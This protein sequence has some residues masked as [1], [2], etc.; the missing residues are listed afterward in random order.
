M[1]QAKPWVLEETWDGDSVRVTTSQVRTL[2]LDV[3]EAGEAVRFLRCHHCNLPHG[4]DEIHCPITGK[5][6]PSNDGL[7]SVDREVWGMADLIDATVG[8][9]YRIFDVL[10][11]GG[12]GT[13]YEAVDLATGRLAAVKVMRRSL[14]R[15]DR[16]R[17]RFLREAEATQLLDHP[18][19]VRH[20]AAGELPDGSPF[21]ALELLEG[22]PLSRELRELGDRGWLRV[23]EVLTV[24]RQILEGLEAAHARGIVH[25]DIKPDNVFIE[26]TLPGDPISVR[27]LDFGV[28]KVFGEN[29]LTGLTGQEELIGTPQYLAPEQISDPETVCPSTDIWATGIV[30]YQMLTGVTPF[31]GAHL[32]GLLLN[33]ATQPHPEL[34]FFRPELPAYLDALVNRFLQKCPE[35]RFANAAEAIAAVDAVS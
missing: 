32:G 10:G 16:S 35:D 23:D 24:T 8:N 4:V 15:E 6:I 3:D 12:M 5:V 18:R 19:I 13:V 34:R 33:I 31:P 26:D 11:S 9:R 27:L 1:A 14:A 25:R 17:R 29:R 28:A 22:R 21:L 20:L 30:L 2:D 7:A